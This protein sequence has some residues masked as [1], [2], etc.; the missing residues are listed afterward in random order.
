M[1]WRLFLKASIALFA[2]AVV[3]FATTG[4]AL[5]VTVV[6]DGTD[7]P[8]SQGANPSLDYGV[9]DNNGPAMV[10]VTAGDSVTITYVSGLTSAFGGASPSVDGIG[11]VGSVFGS[12][13]GTTGIGSSGA[14]FPSHYIDPLNVGPNNIWLNALIGAFANSAGQVIGNPFAVNDGPLTETVPTGA[15]LL[16]LGVNDDIFGD[17]SGALLIDVSGAGV[18]SVSATPLPATLP[19]FAAGLGA[20]GFLRRRRTQ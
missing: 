3:S 11:Y 16:L 1:R 2:T 4:A 10:G 6:V 12:G 15:T 13:P 17:N 18:S 9:H 8:W 19:L 5:A 20:M 14:F 7:G